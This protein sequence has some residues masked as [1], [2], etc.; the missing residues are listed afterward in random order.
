MITIARNVADELLNFSGKALRMQEVHA[1]IRENAD[2]YVASGLTI[3]SG[4]ELIAKEVKQ[5]KQKLIP[6][7]QVEE[8]CQKI[9]CL[10]DNVRGILAEKG[11]S[12]T[13]VQSLPKLELLQ[14]STRTHRSHQNFVSEGKWNLLKL[15]S[16]FVQDVDLVCCYCTL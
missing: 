9:T 12:S 10:A 15:K 6:R 2:S 14:D 7:A 13:T 1:D 4:L 3:M 8:V 5:C 16:K 11:V